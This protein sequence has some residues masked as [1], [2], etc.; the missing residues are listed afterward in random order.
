MNA[1][2]GSADGRDGSAPGDDKLVVLADVV[3][4]LRLRQ[5][6]V[7]KVQSGSNG[8]GQASWFYVRFQLLLSYCI[9]QLANVAVHLVDG[10]LA[11]SHAVVGRGIA[12]VLEVGAVVAGAL[13]TR[14]GD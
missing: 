10:E 3:G 9:P 13:A 14:L 2:V 5:D 6:E 4:G 7:L 11:G 8:C 12:V 1:S